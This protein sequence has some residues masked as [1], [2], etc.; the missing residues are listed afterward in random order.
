[1][2]KKKTYIDMISS[3]IIDDINEY[4]FSNLTVP[5]T[6]NLGYCLFIVKLTVCMRCFMANNGAHPLFSPNNQFHFLAHIYCVQV[7]PQ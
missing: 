6:L 7:F 5:P 3:Y 1:M 2:Y 4:K